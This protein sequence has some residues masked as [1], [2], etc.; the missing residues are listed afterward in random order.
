M[1]FSRWRRRAGSSDDEARG[2]L[3]SS[4]EKEKVGRKRRRLENSLIKV[5]SKL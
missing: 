5:V 4:L 2:D 1:T 3:K